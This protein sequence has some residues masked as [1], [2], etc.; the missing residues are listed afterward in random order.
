MDFIICMIF[1]YQQITLFFNL[2]FISG[3]GF[4]S[5]QMLNQPAWS[6]SVEF[7]VSA[8]LIYWLV[9]LRFLYLLVFAALAYAAVLKNGCGLRA[10]EEH[11]LFIPA[12]MLRGFAGMALGGALY[13]LR[14]YFK[15]ILCELPRFALP[16]I[17]CVV[18][19]II[20]H[21]LWV[22]TGSTWDLVPLLAVIPFFAIGHS[23][24]GGGVVE[25]LLSS[26]PA[27]WLGKVSFPLYLV[28]SSIIIIGGP[29][30]YAVNWGI[31]PT[32]FIFLGI[33]LLAAEV[34][35]RI[36]VNR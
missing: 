21:A 27:V 28:H 7:W 4:S 30:K 14:P 13:K 33:S 25:L 16:V 2:S 20:V 19:V 10:V 31:W 5:V 24:G 8:L 12:A 22:Q 34:L 23:G 15:I 1:H 11:S 3:T 32:A 6:I 36:V 29:S 9:R 35:N 17:L 18:S 26:R